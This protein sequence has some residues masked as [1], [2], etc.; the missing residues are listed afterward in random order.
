MVQGFIHFLFDFLHNRVASIGPMEE[1]LARVVPEA[2]V[3][4]AHGQMR[5]RE[6]DERHEEAVLVAAQRLDREVER[7]EQDGDEQRE[8][9]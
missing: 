4:T 7:E 2:R 3:I 5:E 9:Q 6:L 8:Q 1:M